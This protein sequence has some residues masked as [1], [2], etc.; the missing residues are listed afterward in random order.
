MNSLLVFQI[1]AFFAATIFIVLASR[2]SLR[3][4]KVHGFYRFFV[5]EL[6]VVLVLLNIP[7][8]VNEP[9]STLQILSWAFLFI[10]LY[11]LFQ[12]VSF[13]KKIGGSVNR[14][15]YNA[16]YKFENTTNIV[17]TGVY[18]Y[19]RHPMYGSLLFL[20]MGT[21]CKNI[22]FFSVLLTILIVIFL[23]LTAKV[24]E[25]ENIKFFGNSYTDYMKHTKMFIPYIL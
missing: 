19:I 23:I 14:K 22:Y 7:Y 9:F 4:V 17:T 20:A 1:A 10:S 2:K 12:S 11:L 16:N 24:E 25:K 21:M 13:L 3:S 6:S 8:W 15:E 5:F 18:K